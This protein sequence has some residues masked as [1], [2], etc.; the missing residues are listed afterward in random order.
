MGV[1]IRI[2]IAEDSLISRK[3]AL[4][5]IEHCG[6]EADSA[7]NGTQAVDMACGNQYDLILMDMFMPELNGGDAAL[8]ISR[9]GVST[10]TVALS[11]DVIGSEELDRCRMRD[12]IQ[13]PMSEN[14][15]KRVIAA[16]CRRNGQSAQPISTGDSSKSDLVFDEKA[17]LE[18]AGGNKDTLAEMLSIFIE[19][20]EKNI[21]RLSANIDA[22]DMQKAKSA[23]HLIKGEAK[24]LGAM[25]IFQSAAAINDAAKSGDCNRCTSAIQ[26]L[27]DCFSEF[28]A[29][30]GREGGK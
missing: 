3:L 17:A 23:A 12:S 28:L 16:Y 13:K 15:L 27:K 5:M 20:T 24:S 4:K 2:L 6:Y 10:P 18:F 22:G 7:E 26:P 21:E 8:E 9:R 25:K 19:G 29:H 30:T 1:K 11:G 14:E